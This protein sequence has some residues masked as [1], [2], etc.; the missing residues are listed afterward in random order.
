MTLR[1][2]G[3]FASVEVGAF[4]MVSTNARMSGISFSSFA[5]SSVDTSSRASFA[6]VATSTSAFIGVSYPEEQFRRAEIVYGTGVGT[7]ANHVR[8][9]FLF[10]D[11]NAERARFFQLQ[12]S[13]LSCDD[14]G[15][16]LG[17]GAGNAPAQGANAFARLFARH[18][19][20]ASRE[21]EGL[22]LE[23]LRRYALFWFCDRYVREQAIQHSRN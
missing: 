20:K 4:W 22:P 5:S 11:W 2:V 8:E 14:I 18:T 1:C 19:L 12:A 21:N 10:K 15:G 3:A 16:L 23:W 13:F 7:L 17:D 9:L 6:R